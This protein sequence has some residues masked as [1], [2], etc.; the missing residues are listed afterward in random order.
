M[1]VVLVPFGILTL[2][3]DRK[4]LMHDFFSSRGAGSILALLGIR[5]EVRGL[6]HVS[7]EGRYVVVANHQS[8]IDTVIL[9]QVLQRRSPIRFVAKRSVFRVPVLG[10]G[11]RRFGHIPVD[12]KSLWSSVA[13]LRQAASAGRRWSTVF[14]PEGTRSRDGRLLPFKQA[15]FKIA[16]RLGLPVLPVTILGSAEAL[17]CGKIV[18]NGPATVVVEVHPPIAASEDSAEIAREAVR[19]IESALSGAGCGPGLWRRSTA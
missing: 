4:Q 3:V 7:R 9:L 12:R 8:L 14:F 19:R 10:W 6:E 5:L 1:L 16:G 11:M 2:R 18:A 13:G 17:P 15:P